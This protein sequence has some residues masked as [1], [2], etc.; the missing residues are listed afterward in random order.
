M[1][2]PL[3]AVLLF[4][5]PLTF[6]CNYDGKTYKHN[7]SGRTGWFTFQC[8][9]N[10]NKG[11][12]IKITGCIWKR[13]GDKLGIGESKTVGFNTGRCYQDG[14]VTRFKE[15]SKC[16]DGKCPT[17]GVDK[18]VRSP[19]K[20]SKSGDKAAATTPDLMC[21]YNGQKLAIGHQFRE[22]QFQLMCNQV[23][24]GWRV[25]VIACFVKGS[26]GAEYKIPVGEEKTLQENRARCYKEGDMIMFELKPIAVKNT[27]AYKDSKLNK[28]MVTVTYVEGTVKNN[29]YG[30]GPG[31]VANVDQAKTNTHIK[32]PDSKTTGKSTVQAAKH[33]TIQC[34]FKG[35][36]Y[37]PGQVFSHDSFRFKCSTDKKGWT[38]SVTGCIWEK[39]KKEVP[40]GE[41]LEEGGWRASCKIGSNGNVDFKETMKKQA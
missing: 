26:A 25:E 14:P 5:M 8:L 10:K 4:A 31:P 3:F 27:L 6:A 34:T 39:F 19:N 17:A 32:S 2:K 18:N 23:N 13:T 36:K 1:M 9:V 22:G 40:L 20:L 41:T 16:K 24:N 38:V 12:E 33:G 28:K 11:W 7:E 29:A 15:E 37:T 30:A 35:K 21:E